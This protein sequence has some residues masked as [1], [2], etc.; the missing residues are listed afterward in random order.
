MRKFARLYLND[1]LTLAEIEQVAKEHGPNPILIL[2]NFPKSA[3]IQTKYRQHNA[4][5]RAVEHFARIM[6]ASIQLYFS[7]GMDH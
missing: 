3:V 7:E 6:E 5:D 2:A 4:D 1:D